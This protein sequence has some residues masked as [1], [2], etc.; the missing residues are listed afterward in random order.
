MTTTTLKR[1]SII[2]KFGAL[3]IAPAIYITKSLYATSQ[4]AV[5]QAPIISPTTDPQVLLMLN[6]SIA[7][8]DL[9]NDRFDAASV[10]SQITADPRWLIISVVFAAIA[11]LLDWISTSR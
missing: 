3:C 10:L 7:A 11:L 1:T 9:I 4:A 2:F 5:A 6:K 8:I